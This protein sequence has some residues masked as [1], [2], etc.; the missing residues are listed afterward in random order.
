MKLDKKKNLAAKVFKVG[1]DRIVFV[2]PRL[3]EIKEAITKEDIRGLSKDG[4]ITIKQI[5]GKRGKAKKKT[6]RS[7]GN[8][9][10]KAKDSKRE[11][12][13]MTRKLRNYIAVLKNKKLLKS[14]EIS[15]IRNKIRNR[16]FRSISQLKDYVKEIK[17]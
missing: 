17:K 1:K 9:R 11:Y 15:D 14:E 2:E 3:E 12:M 5:R 13:L 7:L 16:H 8:I 4:A 6:R 10:K